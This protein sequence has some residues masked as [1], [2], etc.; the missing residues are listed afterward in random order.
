MTDPS[1][2]FLLLVIFSFVAIFK[3]FK[4]VKKIKEIASKPASIS[5]ARQSLERSWVK[6]LESYRGE[7]L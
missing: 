4:F 6:R 7:S 5:L 1:V 3:T 2:K